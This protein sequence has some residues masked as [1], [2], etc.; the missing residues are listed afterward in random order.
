MEKRDVTLK[1]GDQEYVVTPN[2]K[3]L[4]DIQSRVAD[5][6]ALILRVH[7]T[8]KT[9]EFKDM[10]NVF[11][12]ALRA[13]DYDLELNDV[14]QLLFENGYTNYYEQYGDF[15]GLL[16]TGGKAVEEEGN[17]AQR[18]AGKSK[19]NPKAKAK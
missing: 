13:S 18:R 6:M 11:F 9:P 10:A 14:K 19:S 8:G 17:R 4:D 5:P 3:A 16:T 1:M 15:L 2:F 7:A 12:Y